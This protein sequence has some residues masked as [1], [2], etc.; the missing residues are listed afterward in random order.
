MNVG[1]IHPGAMGVSIAASAIASGHRALWASAGRSAETQD[2]ARQHGLDDVGTIADLCAQS[3]VIFSICPPA[4]AEAVA[5]DVA[6]SR[7][8]GIF[9]DANAVSPARMQRIAAIVGGTARVVDGGIIGLPAWKRGTTIHVS[10][11]GCREVA[12]CFEGGLVAVEAMDGAIGDAS[13]LKMCYAALTKGTTAVLCAIIGAAEGLGVREALYKRWEQDG[14]GRSVE[15]EMAV[16]NV[17]A[18]AWRYVDEMEEIS[19]TFAEAGLPEGFHLAAADIYSR[20]SDLKAGP[21][22]SRLEEVL[23]RLARDK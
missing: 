10:G 16:R 5:S 8:K 2:R 1:F 17:T 18:K 19:R 14:E 13:A 12:G 22:P 11:D 23:T 3:D 15:R 4:A 20:L 9:V 21:H 6:A 7:Y